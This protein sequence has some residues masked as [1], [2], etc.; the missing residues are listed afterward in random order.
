MPP[1]IFL[2][3]VTGISAGGSGF[4]KFTPLYF[5]RD[6][7][8]GP[9]SIAANTICIYSASNLNFAIIIFFNQ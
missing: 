6:M 5:L 1:G 8:H 4:A 3:D 9:V 7:L 2:F